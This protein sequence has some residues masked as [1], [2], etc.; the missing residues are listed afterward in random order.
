[1]KEIENIND[2]KFFVDEF[3][4]KVKADLLIGPI[5]TDVIP[6]DWQPHL[7]KMYAFWNAALFGVPGFRGNPF[8]KHAPLKIGPEHFDRWL[9]LF[10]LTID[11]HF[12]GPMAADAK[13]RAELMAHM[14]LS[15]LQKMDGGF[16]KVVA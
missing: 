7:D 5:F 9:A 16:N 13:N 2:I 3:Y 6:E 8:A 4:D 10:F 14:F 12:E 15:R 1:M 11:E